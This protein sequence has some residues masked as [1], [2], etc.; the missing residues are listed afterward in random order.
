MSEQYIQRQN[1]TGQG[2]SVLP[3]SPGSW[4]AIL[5]SLRFPN[6]R[7]ISVGLESATAAQIEGVC[8]LF[9]EKRGLNRH[10]AKTPRKEGE[11]RK[12][13]RE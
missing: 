7:Y 12:L 8:K 11:K 10:D 2:C 6:V 1:G 4:F 3:N 9:R 13:R 5:G